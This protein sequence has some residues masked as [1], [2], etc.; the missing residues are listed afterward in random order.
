[1]KSLLNCLSCGC[2]VLFVACFGLGCT[3]VR[4]R[5][6]ALAMAGSGLAYWGFQLAARAVGGHEDGRLLAKVLKSLSYFVAC[7]GWFAVLP[8]LYRRVARQLARGC[9]FPLVLVNLVASLAALIANRVFNLWW[10]QLVLMA[11]KVLELIV[12]IY[13][14][15]FHDLGHVLALMSFFAA[16]PIALIW[17]W[18]QLEQQSFLGST[19]QTLVVTVFTLIGK[20]HMYFIARGSVT[21]HQRSV[22]IFPL[23]FLEHFW[24]KC[25]LASTPA[26]SLDFIGASLVQSASL[27]LQSTQHG[28]QLARFILTPFLLRSVMLRVMLGEVLLLNQPAWK[29][30]M[31]IEHEVF[32]ASHNVFADICATSAA[33]LLMFLQ[34]LLVSRCGLEPAFALGQG[35]TPLFAAAWAYLLVL[36]VL[37]AYCASWSRAGYVARVKERFHTIEASG[38]AAL[39]VDP[40]AYVTQ[41]RALEPDEADGDGRRI[42]H[43]LTPPSAPPSAMATRLRISGS[44]AFGKLPSGRSLPGASLLERS[45]GPVVRIFERMEEEGGSLERYIRDSCSGRFHARFEAFR[46][47]SPQ[48]PALL[49]DPGTHASSFHNILFARFFGFFAVSAVFVITQTLY[50]IAVTADLIDD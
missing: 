11:M 41:S 37:I 18:R 2:V 44:F 33:G 20:A 48:R 23:Q 30:L 22:V 24:T 19:A 10:P 35:S 38:D 8:W 42:C 29:A 46:E 3:V 39:E 36:H 7:V 5:T 34:G 27:L 47:L 15:S 12:A 26:F 17:C 50:M 25:L 13:E 43:T 31:L 9:L 28:R 40:V 49:M 32:R 21:H 6:L 4:R 45:C 16:Y 1:V 14:Q